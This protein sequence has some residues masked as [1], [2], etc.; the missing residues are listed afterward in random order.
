M[1]GIFQQLMAAPGLKDIPKGDWNDLIGKHATSPAPFAALVEDVIARRVAAERASWEKET[2]TKVEAA[3]K[4]S[5]DRVRLAVPSP[6]VARSNG[7]PTN[8]LTY[9]KYQQMLRTNDPALL[10]IPAAEIDRVTNQWLQEAQRR[11]N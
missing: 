4:A 2:A 7:S 5:A 1:P 8:G 3:E 10:H 6:D 11:G 9:Q